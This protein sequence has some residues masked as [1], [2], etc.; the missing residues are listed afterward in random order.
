LTHL[1]LLEIQLVIAASRSV[2]PVTIPEQDQ[3]WGVAVRKQTV[4][5][6]NTLG[7]EKT[8]AMKNRPPE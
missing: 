4:D 1:P 6:P 3:I 2:T 5:D 7:V 8:S